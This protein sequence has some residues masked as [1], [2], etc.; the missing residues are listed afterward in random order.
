VIRRLGAAE[1]SPLATVAIVLIVAAKF[2]LPLLIIRFPFAAGWANFALD[3][4]DGDLLIPLGLPNEI[5]QPVDKISDWV[6]YVAIVVVGYR[7]QW[8]IRRLMLGLFV[9]RSIGQIAFLVTEEE[10]FLALFPNFLEPLFLVSAS[11]LTWQR[12]VRH[13]P[14]WQ[15]RGFAV[16]H[17]FRWPIG[18][19]IV[20]YKLQDEYFT[21]VGNIDRSEWLQQFFEGLFGG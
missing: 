10:L 2:V 20:L 11:L 3:G 21:H 6:T 16:L 4:I 8:P 14:D 13:Q 12:V 1:S 5:Y 9:F 7:N 15:E 17:R 18:V 19:V